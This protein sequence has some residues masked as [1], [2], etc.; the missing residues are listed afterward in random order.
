MGYSPALQR[1]YSKTNP[2]SDTRS[3]ISEPHST[4]QSSN[5]Q[6]H[7]GSTVY[8]HTHTHTHTHTKTLQ[9]AR[10]S[11]LQKLPSPKLGKPRTAKGKRVPVVVKKASPRRKTATGSQS[12]GNYLCC[13]DTYCHIQECRASCQEKPHRGEC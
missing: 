5:S 10:R 4:R 3:P 13:M 11:K 8:T 6:K 9:M 2:Y 1:R 12:G 7:C